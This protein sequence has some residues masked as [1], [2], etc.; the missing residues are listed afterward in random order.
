M[1]KTDITVLDDLEKWKDG[2][3]PLKVVIVGRT[4]AGKSTLANALTH[5]NRCKESESTATCTQSS[6]MTSITVGND[7]VMVW[8]TPGFIKTDDK[9]TEHIDKKYLK[10]IYKKISIKNDDEYVILYAIDMEITRFETNSPDLKVMNELTERYGPV[11]WQHTVIL[12]TSANVFIEMLGK[13]DSTKRYH[14][15]LDNWKNELHRYIENEVK[16]SNEVV[17]NVQVIPAG[18]VNKSKLQIDSGDRP[19]LCNVWLS[20]LHAADSSRKPLVMNVLMHE[21]F[22]SDP[23]SGEML[24]S[25][26]QEHQVIYQKKAIELGSNS[27]SIAGLASSFLHLQKLFF[28][29]SY[30]NDSSA[31]RPT[32]CISQTDDRLVQYWDRI[33]FT[34][35]IAVVG[36]TGSG[37]TALINSLF[38]GKLSLKESDNVHPVSST[39]ISKLLKKYEIEHGKFVF[40]VWD[41]PGIERYFECIPNPDDVN[42][43]LF[44]IDLLKNESTAIKKIKEFSLKLGEMAW[45]QQAIIVLTYANCIEKNVISKITSWKDSIIKKLE[46]VLDNETIKRIKFIPAGYHTNDVIP[47]DPERTFWVTRLW[48]EMISAV[49]AEYQPALTQ[50]LYTLYHLITRSDDSKKEFLDLLQKILQ[51]LNRS[52]QN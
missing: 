47:G 41:T 39:D 13:K 11:I 36:Q 16:V 40:T 1:A 4:G 31:H 27:E 42:L 24:V 25:F 20:I 37:K 8:D 33:S 18:H 51:E 28:E 3:H 14:E 5:T 48:M 17:R 21:I 6:K 45:N 7:K 15:K 12:L 10:D 26:I 23:V 52:I 30:P 38:K 32:R 44:C 19:W 22:T 35:K 43:Y 50:F 34:V 49:R 29:H 46:S 9:K 2:H